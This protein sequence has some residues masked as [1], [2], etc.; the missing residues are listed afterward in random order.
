MSR[1]HGQEGREGAAGAK[2]SLGPR[3]GQS[4]G[5]ASQG[6][7]VL[8]P[9][10]SLVSRAVLAACWWSDMGQAGEGRPGAQ[11]GQYLESSGTWS[12]SKALRSLLS[13]TPRAVSMRGGVQKGR[14]ERSRS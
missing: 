3:E 7:K 11:A 2:P 1:A 6:D 10:E 5:Y 13:L 12:L 14:G 9:H 8:P 4:L